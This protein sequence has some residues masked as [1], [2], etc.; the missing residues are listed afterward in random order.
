MWTVAVVLVLSACFSPVVS[1]EARKAIAVLYTEL[2][3]D[4]AIA[5]NKM[6]G[7][8]EFEQANPTS[9]LSITVVLFH[10]PDLNNGKH[11]FHIHKYGNMLGG[12]TQTLGHYNPLNKEHGAPEDEIR[13]VGDLGNIQIVNNQFTGKL[14]DKTASLYG[15]LSIVGRGVVLHSGEDD[16]GKGGDVS[17]KA[18]GN[19]GSRYAC[20]VISVN[21][22][23]FNRD[24]RL[25]PS[26]TLFLLL[27]T[28]LFLLK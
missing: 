5:D 13:H 4:N 28:L 22:D 25:A 9:V 11:G 1:D 8:A 27:T 2:T 7:Y 21:S 16:L 12:C 17:S 10:D 26:I 20:G 19:A 18:T 24:S 6:V 14:Q 15:G 3:T 23:N